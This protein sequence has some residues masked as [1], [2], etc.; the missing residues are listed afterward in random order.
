M[1]QL[2]LIIDLLRLQAFLKSYEHKY[3]SVIMD[4]VS[5]TISGMLGWIFAISHSS[6]VLSQFNDTA[7]LYCTN[8]DVV[9][10]YAKTLGILPDVDV[11]L[12]IHHF[13][14]S[15]YVVMQRNGL[16]LIFKC[17]DVMPSYQPGHTHADALSVVVV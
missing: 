15:G 5:K 10:S 12:P 4:R 9:K 13:E 6:E 1:Y 3:T 7:Q 8:I 2:I 16:K 14:D 11:E 17:A